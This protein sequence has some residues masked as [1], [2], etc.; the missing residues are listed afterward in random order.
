MCVFVFLG[1][2][3]LSRKFRFNLF[4]NANEQKNLERTRKKNTELELIRET[5]SR[6]RD[7]ESIVNENSIVSLNFFKGYT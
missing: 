3:R 4:R 1:A 6:N 7:L 2:R 5:L